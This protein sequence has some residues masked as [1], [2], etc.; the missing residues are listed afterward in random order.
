MQCGMVGGFWT[1]DALNAEDTGSSEAVADYVVG[2][3]KNG[4]VILMHNGTKATYD[5][6]PIMVAGL[7]AKGYKI[8]TLAQLARD[9]GINVR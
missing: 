3:A 7:R 4:A 1:L 5:A 9:A 6:V 8:V 2:H